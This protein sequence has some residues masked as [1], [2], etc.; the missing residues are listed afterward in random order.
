MICQMQPSVAHGHCRLSRPLAK[1]CSRSHSRPRINIHTHTHTRMYTH[2]LPHTRTRA[3]AHTHTYVHTQKHFV[4]VQQWGCSKSDNALMRD[5]LSTSGLRFTEGT[6]ILCHF[7]SVVAVWLC[8]HKGFQSTMITRMVNELSW[9]F[10]LLLTFYGY[11]Y[12]IINVCA[13]FVS[14]IGISPLYPLYSFFF[15]KIQNNH[16]SLTLSL[17]V[18]HHF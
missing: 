11:R 1:P 13:L 4:E 15:F 14:S 3:H 5:Y 18:I 6:N 16:H 8:S 9:L 2:T 12:S 10:D 7:G 17:S